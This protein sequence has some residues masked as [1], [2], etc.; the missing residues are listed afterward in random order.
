MT[1]GFGFFFRN[2][3]VSYH[4]VSVSKLF[5]EPAQEPGAKS[6]KTVTVSEVLNA[7]TV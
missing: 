6:S 7:V 1:H 3:T 4:L 2:D 5:K